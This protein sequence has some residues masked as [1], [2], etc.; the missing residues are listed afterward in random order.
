MPRTV[1]GISVIISTYNQPR[2]L[3]KVLWGYAAQTR[4]DFEL[5]IADDGSGEETGAVIDAAGTRFDGRLRRIWHPDQGF[6]KCEILNRAI[7][8]A[9]GDYLVFSDG[10]CIPRSD[11]I[12]WHGRLARPGRFVSGGVVW[13]PRA[14]SEAITEEDIARGS[15]AS[16]RWLAER[17]WGAGRHRLRVLR[18]PGVA[19]LLDRVTTTRPTFNGHNTSAWRSD[20]FAVNGF[21][22]EMG[23]GG[24]DRA[25]GERLENQGV[26]GLQARHRVVAFHLDHDR[27]YQRTDVVRRNRALRARIR[28]EHLTR[29]LTG[30]SELDGS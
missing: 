23:Y 28:R 29:A 6:R 14:L 15:L 19:R 21:D 10:D 30:I 8:A 16:S 11:F 3:E 1:P 5:L 13:L 18:N 4:S 24:L 12:E 22:S 17:G 26:R 20:I 2:W 7:V 9:R 25:V 27:P